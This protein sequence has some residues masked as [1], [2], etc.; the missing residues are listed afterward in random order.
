MITRGFWLKSEK[1]PIVIANTWRYKDY[2]YIDKYDKTVYRVYS[3][4]NSPP[5][6]INPQFV[7]SRFKP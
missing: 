4:E 1:A 5:I 6:P 2:I 3:S 7:I